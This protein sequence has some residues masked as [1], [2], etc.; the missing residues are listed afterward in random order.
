MRCPNCGTELRSTA[1]F[2]NVCGAA[3]GA[4]SAQANGDSMGAT[5]EAARGG[6]H[7]PVAAPAPGASFDQPAHSASAMPPLTALGASHGPAVGSQPLGPS[8]SEAG[9]STRNGPANTA[10]LNDRDTSVS[11]EVTQE[12]ALLG[13]RAAG[14]VPPGSGER[15]LGEQIASDGVLGNSGVSYRPDDQ[16]PWPLPTNIILDGRYRVE[17]LLSAGEDECAYRVT[18]LRGYERCWA[19]GKVYGASGASDRFCHECGA[20]MLAREYVMRER[21]LAE[22]EVAPGTGVDGAQ[23]PPET[24]ESGAEAPRTFVQSGRAYR[25]EPRVQQRS[26]FPQGA[27]LIAG[28][29]T[30]LG[31]KRSGE[32]N[33]DS[34]LVLVLDR[35]HENHTLPFGVFVV[36]DGLGGHASGHRAS[37]LA[38][39]VLVHT[40]LRQVA[41]PVVGSPTDTPV[42]ETILANLLADAVRAANGSLC[43][44]NREAGLDAGS[45]VVTVLIYGETAH[46]A[47]VGDS[48]AYVCDDEGLRRIT[49][50]HSLVQQLVAGGLIGPD[51]VY[52]H[53]QR[54]QIFRS[55]GD[56]PDL[57]VDLFAQQLRPGMRLLLCSDG[58]WE[59]MRDP[60]IEQ[61]LRAAP[62]PQAACDALIAAANEGGGDDNITVVVVEAR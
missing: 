60:Q 41:L 25:V 5:A 8:G 54:N 15:R 20:D 9:R 22:S 34:A 49:T 11:D 57:A 42:D 26:S 45:T 48:R 36:A 38:V 23:T 12:H 16:L 2:C 46:I 28:A 61:V 55:L 51:D 32:E 27:R 29:A 44:A 40:I 31:R 53:P 56:D 3:T 7:E 50:D 21:R 59:M 19:C 6:A 17:M 18:D 35:V 43:A 52:T 1:R 4:T 58:L 30:D 24:L 10:Q 13:A 62:D 37:R 14:A 39:N 33:E 47:N